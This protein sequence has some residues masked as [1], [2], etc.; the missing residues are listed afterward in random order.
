[1][2]SPFLL[3]FP[4]RALRAFA[5]QNLFTMPPEGANKNA[6]IPI[7]TSGAVIAGFR[8]TTQVRDA[9]GRH[10]LSR[11]EYLS[12]TGYK[13]VSPLPVGQVC[14]LPSDIRYARLW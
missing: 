14:N 13:P 5:V 2:V 8:G 4:L 7:G 9:P 10:R 3:F 12:I 11:T 1:M 6:L